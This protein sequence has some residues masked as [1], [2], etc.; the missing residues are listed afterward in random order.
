[1]KELIEL[2][3][4][5]LRECNEQYEEFVYSD[6]KSLIWN[7]GEKMINLTLS[8]MS[9]EMKELAEEYKKSSLER[10]VEILKKLFDILRS[11]EQKEIPLTLEGI[12]DL[13][14]F[15]RKMNIE[16]GPERYLPPYFDQIEPNCL[17]KE[18]QIAA[19]MRLANIKSFSAS[20]IKHVSE[21]ECIETLD[22]IGKIRED[23]KK[24]NIQN[25]PLFEQSLYL[26]EVSSQIR[27]ATEIRFH[28]GIILQLRNK[29]WWMFDPYGL[30]LGKLPMQ[31]QM[32]EV[33]KVLSSSKE[34]KFSLIYSQEIEKRILEK[35]TEF[36]DWIERS[37]K[38]D[39]LKEKEIVDLDKLVDELINLNVPNEIIESPTFG[40]NAD[41]DLKEKIQQ[42]LFK[43]FFMKKLLE[44]FLILG[45]GIKRIIDELI[46]IYHLIA[47]YKFFKWFDDSR[48]NGQIIHPAFEVM[49]SEYSIGVG[50]LNNL[51]VEFNNFFA[52]KELVKFLPIQA[53]IGAYFITTGDFSS[54]LSA[55]LISILKNQPIIHKI[56]K[57][58]F[59]EVRL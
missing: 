42:P 12:I 16:G 52:I 37:K 36:F 39:P 6:E 15:E 23:M 58:I 25:D 41:S 56:L 26:Q 59:K 3:K 22:F 34:P 53:Q 27:L 10:Q 35:K 9:K 30:S 38:L 13:I 57:D 24:R 20:I 5:A 18:M 33:D 2:I 40:D 55:N 45:G 44:N 43:K 28:S 17:G 14:N 54:P 46:T 29:E 11:K 49:N 32:K 48:L 50:V 19:F 4:F 21:V 7:F 1:M 47:M 31:E 8:R 51:A